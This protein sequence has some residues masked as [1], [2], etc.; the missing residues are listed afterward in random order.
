MNHRSK[1]QYPANYYVRAAIKQIK[2]EAKD[3]FP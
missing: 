1:T 2:L 3:V